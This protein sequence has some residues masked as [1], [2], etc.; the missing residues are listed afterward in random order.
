MSLS[1]EALFMGFF[2]PREGGNNLSLAKKTVG[3]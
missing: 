1:N 3:L 2:L